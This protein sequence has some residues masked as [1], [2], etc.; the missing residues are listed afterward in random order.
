MGENKPDKL[1]AGGKA[2]IGL[3]GLC[4]LGVILVVAIG[5]LF[6]P[7]AETSDY[8]SS[9]EPVQTTSSEP[10]ESESDYKASCESLS[11][12][13]LNKN[14]EAYIGKRVKLSGTVVQIMESYGYTDIRMDV[15]D[16]FGDT[17]YVTYDG[18]TSALEDSSITIYGE[19]AGSYTYE[20]QAGWMITLPQIDA[21]YITVE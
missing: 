15:N 12:K 1:S 20:S 21:M 10:E 14:P 13:E 9:S 4:C 6:A 5:G 8:N 18:S 11:F 2:V 19:V 16:N 7:E 17:V 3:V